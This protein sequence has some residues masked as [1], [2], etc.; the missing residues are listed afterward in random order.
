M[1]EAPI[2]LPDASGPRQRTLRNSIFCRGVGLHGG[3]RVTCWLHPAAT[4][5]GIVFRR[6]DLGRGA[7]PIPAR[8]ENL[9][10]DR[11]GTGLAAPDGAGVMTVEH[12]MAAFAGLGVDNA[13]VEL[14]G[15]EVPILDGSAEPFAFLI[16]AA[17]I[18]EQDAP[19]RV[20][21][22]TERIA[23]GEAG[24]WAELTPADEGLT[25]EVA[26]EFSHPM[27]GRQG[28]AFRIE[29]ARFRRELAPARTFGFAADVDRMRAE[30]LARGG[31]LANAVVLD[32]RGVLNDEGLRFADEFVR[33]KALDALG[34]L[35][36]CGARI[37]G[38]YRGERPGHN[39]NLRLAAALL[40][41]ALPEA[42]PHQAE[43]QARQA[44]AARRRRPLAAPAELAVAAGD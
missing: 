15:P 21:A 23:V 32:D 34:D 3:Q 13:V 30:G 27:I 10:H 5:Q 25:L 43:E 29:P 24:R 22:V 7:L 28:A 39:L 42:A 16:E 12:L 6:A 17:G 8:V 38:R 1:V 19:A 4:G 40:Q 33:H 31:S 41:S 37:R 9:C 44:A 20:I 36:L 2:L 35:A 26:I 18:E 11:L 14:D